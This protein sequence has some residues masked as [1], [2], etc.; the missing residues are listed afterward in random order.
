[1]RRHPTKQIADAPP[2]RTGWPWIEATEP[3]EPVDDQGSPLISIVMP[4]LNQGAFIEAA[5]RSVLLQSY[6]RVELI[7]VDGGST[8]A[9]ADVIGK[10]SAC[11]ASWVCER[12]AGPA[13]ALN[14]GFRQ[15]SGEILGFLNADDFLMPNALSKVARA[16]RTHPGVD[17]ISGH[18]FMA[19]A[20]GELTTPVFSDEWNLAHLIHT[21]CVLVQPAT[22][23]RRAIFLEVG[24][25]SDT[26]RTAWD[27]ELW[28][29]MALAG[30]AFHCVDEFLAVSRLHA[31]SITGSP[32]LRQQRLE[33]AR[34]VRQKVR[35]R[36]EMTRDRVYS[37]FHRVRKFSGHPLRTLNQRLFL[38]SALRRWSL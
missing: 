36:P 20:S 28:A 33:D 7:V 1:M 14:K 4:S 23:F 10:Y 9:S 17:V 18:G 11:L 34:V 5:I 24:G 21:A 35:G 22:F 3:S 6:P 27:M 26:T 15:A 8:D 12:D 25:F 29:D 31:A 32:Q 16:F 37:V 19:D 2:A 30:A 38:Y 13:D